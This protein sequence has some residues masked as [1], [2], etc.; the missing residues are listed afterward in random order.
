MTSPRPDTVLDRWLTVNMEHWWNTAG[1]KWKYS[2]QTRSRCYFLYHKH[3]VVCPGI[4]HESPRNV[5]YASYSLTDV[6][7]RP[8]TCIC[9]TCKQDNGSPIRDIKV[10]LPIL[11]FLRSWKATPSKSA[12]KQ[13]VGRKEI[14]KERERE[15]ETGAFKFTTPTCMPTPGA[16]YSSC[17]WSRQPYFAITKT[18][19]RCPLE[20]QVPLC[21]LRSSGLI[22]RPQVSSALPQDTRPNLSTFVSLSSSLQPEGT[23][24]NME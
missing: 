16:E 7:I 19:V 20:R 5:G 22:P 12:T 4:E 1:G 13:K 24:I 3:Q 6:Y 11:V 8:V 10:R 18:V 2:E 21:F 15:R 17:N 9:N 23:F 14:K